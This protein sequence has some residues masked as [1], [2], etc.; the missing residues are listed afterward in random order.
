MDVW[1]VP[2]VVPA[3]TGDFEHRWQSFDNSLCLCLQLVNILRM[4]EM[5]SKRSTLRV[6]C[7]VDDDAHADEER[8]WWRAFLKHVRIQARVCVVSLEEDLRLVEASVPDG[9]NGR[10]EGSLQRSASFDSL[11]TDATGDS[12]M[13]DRTE[14]VFVPDRMQKYVP[15]ALPKFLLALS[16]RLTSTSGR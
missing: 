1:A 12:F 10:G 6:F 3:S 16:W 13:S 7:L 14:T 9:R 5:W 11:T 4:N 2:I 15:Y 8:L